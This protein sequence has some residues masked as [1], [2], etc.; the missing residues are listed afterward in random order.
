MVP[1]NWSTINTTL[2]VYK[3]IKFAGYKI[4]IQ[5]SVVFYT[6]AINN[7]RKKFKK[8]IPFIAAAKG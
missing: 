5:K 4:N 2:I 8:T 3:F 6:L 7:P 1:M